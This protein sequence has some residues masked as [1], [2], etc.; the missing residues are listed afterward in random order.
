MWRASMAI[1]M[2]RS[3][4]RS[5]ILSLRYTVFTYWRSC[6]TDFYTRGV[7]TSDPSPA[8]LDAPGIPSSDQSTMPNWPPV[9]L[10]DSL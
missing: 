2:P 7:R 6:R 8:A 9:T 1:T 10:I 3:K 5:F 4:S